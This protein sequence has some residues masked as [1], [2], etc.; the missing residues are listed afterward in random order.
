MVGATTVAGVTYT[1]Q[2]DVGH[3]D[4]FGIL[5][6]VGLNIGG[7]ESSGNIVGGAT[8]GATGVDATEGNWSTFTATYVA[9]VTG[10]SISIILDDN[11]PAEN[12]QGY[13]D[14]V[15]LSDNITSVG[16]TPLPAA[17]PLFAGGLGVMGLLARRRKRR[18]AAG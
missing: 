2:V 8:Y 4:G 11:A 15:R 3:R 5:S 18:S 10:L 13:W 6:L 16:A 17:L 14:N 12:Q 1:L 9:S 7:T